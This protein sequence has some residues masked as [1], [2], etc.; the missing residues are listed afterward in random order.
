MSCRYCYVRDRK[1]TEQADVTQE[2]CKQFI[3]F[4]LRESGDEVK[5]NFFGGEP[6]LCFDCIRFVVEHGRQKAARAGKGIIFHIYSNGTLLDQE[7]GD[8]I[9][10]NKIGIEISLDGPP[11]VHNKNRTFQGGRGSFAAVYSNL[12]NFRKRHPGYPLNIFTVITDA[13]IQLWLHEISNQLKP[14][15]ITFNPLTLT[16]KQERCL[17]KDYLIKAREFFE[18]KVYWHRENFIHGNPAFDPAITQSMAFILSGK[19]ARRSSCQAGINSTIITQAGKIF[20]CPL[21]VGQED[22]IIGDIHTGF[23]EEKLQPFLDWNVENIPACSACPEKYTCAGGCAFRAYERHG[24]INDPFQDSCMLTRDN[25]ALIRKSMI[26]IAARAPESLI[27]LLEDNP[28]KKRVRMVRPARTITPTNYVVRVTG[29]CNFSCDYCYDQSKR[30]GTVTLDK[31]NAFSIINYILRNSTKEPVVCLFGGEPLLNWPACRLFIERLSVEAAQ[32]GKKPTLHIVTNGSLITREIALFFK[33]YNVV[34]QISIDGTEEDHNRHRKLFNGSGSY[35]SVLEGVQTLR[36]YGHRFIDAQIVLT[37][38]NTDMIAI[39]W[40][41][42][43]LGFRRLFFMRASQAGGALVQWSEVEIRRLMKARA[44]FFPFFMEYALSGQPEID[45]NFAALVAFGHDGPSGVCDCGRSELLINANGDIHLCPIVFSSGRKALGN[46]ITAVRNQGIPLPDPSPRDKDC[47]RCWAYE[48]CGGGCVVHCQKCKYIPS[49]IHR[50]EQR[51]WCDLL[52]ADF[53]RAIL[54]HAILKSAN[55]ASLEKIQSL[56]LP[57]GGK[58]QAPQE[59]SFRPEEG[60]HSAIGLSEI[61]D[62]LLLSADIPRARREVAAR[63]ISAR[64]A[65]GRG[66]TVTERELSKAMDEFQNKNG[67]SVADLHVL[68]ESAGMA[69]KKFEDFFRMDVLVEK[70]KIVLEK[71]SRQKALLANPEIRQTIR[72]QI[73]KDW[74]RKNHLNQGSGHDAEKKGGQA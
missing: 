52:R 61:V 4:V 15:F 20:P 55:I 30:E 27:A 18:K 39:A 56:F 1:K 67:L 45:M 53:G 36:E 11:D 17:G 35:T 60:R 3:E 22:Q 28:M 6:L 69:Q 40:K 74:M 72:D 2:T 71:T 7:I 13:D 24:S 25:N 63:N 54:A 51:L 48:R 68:L 47:S 37:P 50:A 5:I 64:A 49:S 32:R 23:I 65:R 58:V 9:V 29:A 57:A 26:A 10:R 46:C 38:G 33:Q 41:L 14:C 8:F 12:L 62:Y 59:P 70:F 34:V 31:R 21:F 19:K 44:E 73:F 43:S 16:A 66:I 42:K